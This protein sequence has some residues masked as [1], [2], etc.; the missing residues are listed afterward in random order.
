MTQ[1]KWTHTNTS[2]HVLVRTDSLDGFAQQVEDIDFVDLPGDD[3]QLIL[4]N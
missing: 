4:L 2:F 3:G 1:T